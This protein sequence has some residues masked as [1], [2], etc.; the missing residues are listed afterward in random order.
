VSH[1]TID[2]VRAKSRP[3]IQKSQG[4]R[5]TKLKSTDKRRLVCMITS[6]K[7]DS[8]T[9]VTRELRDISNVEVSAETVCCA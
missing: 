6:G 8:A 2:R 7:A 1:A 3:N 4:G 5:P 9:Q